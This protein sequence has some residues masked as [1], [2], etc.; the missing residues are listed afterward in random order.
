[1]VDQPMDEKI[2]LER[3][4]LRLG[5]AETDEQLQASICKFLPPVLLKLSSSQEGVRKK[6]MELLIHINRRIKSRPQVQ[7]PVEALLL[8][9]QDPA[10]SSFVINFTIIYIKLGYPRMEI[11][12]QAELI[13]SVLNAIQGK[14][15]SHQDSLMLIIMPALAHVNIPLDPEKRAS[16]LGLQDEPQVAKQ[17][18][19]FMLD[20][21]LLPYGS[22]GQS[23]NQQPGQPI[24]WSQYPVPPGLSEYA[25]KRVI[26]E[27]PPT[28]E[29]LEQTKLG[30]VKFLAGGFFSDSD[31]LIHLIVAAADTRFSVANLADL[32]LKKIANL[33]D[34]SSM[35]LAAPLYTLFLGTDALATQKEVKQEIKRTPASIRIR[36]KLLHYLC[37]VTKAGFIIPPCI[38]VIFESLYGANNTNSKLKSLA[39]QFTSNLVQQCS[40]TPIVRVAKVIQNGMMKLITEEAEP[41]HR[42][43]AYTIIGQL[44][45]RIPSLVNKDLSLLQN[46]FDMLAS[47]D[48]DLRRTVRDALISM[49]SAF[50]LNKDDDTGI[51]L[52][53]GLLSAHI[54]SLEAH[55]RFV[56]VHYS[57]TVFPPDHAPSRYLLLLASGD[58]K[59]EVQS[60]ALKS[61]YGTSYKNERSKCL[62]KEVA[63]PDF[64]QLMSYIHSK[65]QVRVNSNNKVTVGNKILPFN[66]ATFVE[67]ISYL[68][69]CLARS[70][71][72]VI[73]ND[74]IEHPSEFTPLIGRYLEKLYKENPDS[75][76]H[77][78]DIVVLFGQVTGDEVA[79]SALLEI[80]GT[81]PTYIV[82]R[83]AKEQSW[84]QS[85][86]TSSK[87]Y[88]R[89]LAA[90]IYAVFLA[91]VPTNEFE[92][93]ISKMLKTTKDK[94]L[95]NQQGAILAL[96][97]SMERKLILR[98]SEDKNTLVNWNTYIDTVKAICDFL[99]VNNP[100]LL[101]AAIN[102]IGE[103]GKSFSLPL[104]SEAEKNTSKKSVADKLFSIF[105]NTKSN[106]KVKEK[107]ALSLGYICVG[108]EFPHTKMI[109]E[110]FI[111]TANETK[112]INIHLSVGEALVC[113]VQG[114]ASPE[115]RDAWKTL[116]S[117]HS[118]PYTKESNDLLV[119]V[120]DK[121]L[122]IASKPHP[123]IRQ[124]VC[125]WL[126]TILKHNSKRQGIIEK[127]S[128]IQS[129]FMDFLSENSDIVQDIASKGL[130][131]VY[132][133]CSEDKKAALVSAITN[134]LLHGRRE[135]R[136]VTDDT[137]LFEEGAL[138]KCPTGGN[139]T[140]YKE[141]CSLATDLNKPE[142]TYRFL[143]LANH[144]AL[145]TSKKGAALGFSQLASLINEDLSA[146]L[147]NIIPKLYRY[148][149]D[150][151][152]K[153]QQSFASIWR[154]IVPSTS[155]ALE[156]H[157]KEI[158]DD[159]TQN[160]T[161]NQFRVRIS[162]CLA[163][164]DLLKSPNVSINYVECAPGLWKQLFRVMD[165]I[166]EGTRQEATNTTKVFSRVC[167]RQCDAS[168]GKTGEELLQVILPVLLEEG[169]THT[170]SQIRMISLQTVSQLVTT[171][172][173]L[174]KPSI[175]FLIPALLNSIG[176]VENANL[177]YLR[178]MTA[179]SAEVQE[180]IDNATAQQ[181]K[182]HTTTDTM[183]KCIQYIDAPILKELMPKVIDLIKSSLKLGTK[184]ACSNFLIKLSSHMK[185]ELQPYAG[186]ILAALINGLTD[187][188]AGIKKNNAVTIGHIVGCAKESSL[189]KLFN[190]LNTWYMERED[191]SIRLAIGQT[192]QSINNHNQD[193]LKKYSN[194][195]MPLTF[196]AMHAEK[197]VGENEKTVELWTELWSEITPGTEA[198][199]RQ[200]LTVITSTLNTALESASW[201]TK[202]QAANAVSTVATKLGATID[203]EARNSLLNILV[204]G[205]QGRTW[206]GKT[207]LL[208][209]L[210]TLACNSKDALKNDAKL[211][212]TIVEALYKESKKEGLEYRRHAFKALTEVLHELDEDKYKQV[213]DI[214]QEVLPKLT[215]KGDDDDDDSMEENKKKREEKI[216]LQETIYEGLGKAWPTCKETQDQYCVQFVAHC[217][218]TLPTST[219]PVQV[220]IL[221]TLNRYVDKLALLKMDYNQC[222]E[223]D[224]KMLDTICGTLLKI[225]RYAIGIAK[226]T[227]IRK[228]ALNIVISLSRKLSEMQNHKQSNFMMA[229]MKD[230]LP[231]LSKDNQPEIRSR[232]VDIKDML[233]L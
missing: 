118:V 33:L 191:D 12:K 129:A 43:M 41:A 127:L 197:V 154:S 104:P 179:N 199:I 27:T 165:D 188:N 119:F 46:F 141:I 146:Q 201:T 156:Q 97:Y 99:N 55:V 21:L 148:Q 151:I 193:I 120:L 203:E 134:Q 19:N 166:H 128:D 230:M 60:E 81:I 212:E 75:L 7:L 190:M 140:T 204:N 80:V 178:N 180:A 83:Y 76:Y 32:E 54:E 35:Q 113:C 200:N 173:S 51:S 95:E 9:Y 214:A 114:P 17:L 184:L 152:P 149:F 130:Y 222:T 211:K 162:C 147:P 196:F 116:P 71:N 24:D 209:A 23:E 100:M 13:P 20:M 125:T 121:L 70:A 195:V 231:E 138:G 79:L 226:Y 153:T 205:L 213:Y 22:I 109:V 198:G 77:Y 3:V 218:D 74:S 126:L 62:A 93:Q 161:N 208:N 144:N 102:G 183:T 47:T 2:L 168:H 150:P 132:T 167:I 84:I 171:A 65:V 210:S 57:A 186:K 40:L 110:K 59:L 67:I 135:V 1:M 229:L 181:T 86:L 220:S 202:A 107:V 90:K 106:A 92:N 26:G 227:R 52:M 194:I 30:I 108:E 224:K 16:L 8:Q 48:G 89:D 34:W 215:K 87:E 223:N 158:L 122:S 38:Q 232:V 216:K 174:L 10:A 137:Q 159:I 233:K 88:V 142:L 112:D 91:Y 69:L 221:T 25:F 163:L 131:L 169:I 207:R 115:A 170:V 5:S 64:P 136:K 123:N 111:E 73:Q 29:Q 172:G 4:F 72:V 143:H 78:V 18:L 160:L 94:V 31:I 49:T 58:S 175:P 82:E 53:V 61:L 15:L 185:H 28:A 177:L 105:I 139:M 187:R 14:P 103:I 50:V 85:L 68:R 11:S 192:L 45:Q 145:W 164:A 157:H 98:R 217:F 225:L 155:K 176:E 6:V 219:R 228:E 37:R 42:L 182:T 133:S 66:T 96:S 56:A 36:L 124:A 206:N 189:D 39:L 44:G 117:E 63:L 101:T